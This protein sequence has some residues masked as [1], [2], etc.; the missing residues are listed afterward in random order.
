MSIVGNLFFKNCFILIQ[1]NIFHKIMNKN[2]FN[3]LFYS[4]LLIFCL[5]PG[6]ANAQEHRIGF[7][8][9][10]GLTNVS[11]PKLNVEGHQIHGSSSTSSYAAAVVIERTFKK[12]K[13]GINVE[14]G[15]IK[16]GFKTNGATGLL[17]PVTA[18]YY[19][20]L[21][22]SCFVQPLGN[23]RLRLS[24]GLEMAYLL[25]TTVNDASLTPA[26]K[27]L[28]NKYDL[29]GFIG[30]QA[31]VY[32]KL[33]LG[34]RV[35]RAFTPVTSVEYSNDQGESLGTSGWYNMNAQLYARYYFYQ[36]TSK[37]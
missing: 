3:V 6:N 12:N 19:S 9:G 24:C 32:H 26:A 34:V 30:V 18:F 15:F 14:P 31:R 36:S 17:S 28:Y 16:R 37:S 27:E 25:K 33:S 1:T 11:M 20:S 35:N 29:L 5:F 10:A 8:V 22:I 21:P 13:L 23:D 4:A 7:Q 2:Y